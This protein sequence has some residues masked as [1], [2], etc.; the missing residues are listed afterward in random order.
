MRGAT[1]MF[2]RAESYA[3]PTLIRNEPAAEASRWASARPYLTDKRKRTILHRR[4]AALHCLLLLCNAAFS[5]PLRR[6]VTPL[7]A[8]RFSTSAV[9][10]ATLAAA[11]TAGPSND[12]MIACRQLASTYPNLVAFDPQLGVA[13]QTTAL[14]AAYNLTNSVYWNAQN[15]DFRAACAFLPQ[16]AHH[17]SSA[18]KLLNEYKSVPFALKSGG[19]NPAPLY[20]S[21][22][23]GI[24]ISFEPNLNKTVRTDD[25]HHFIVGAGARW[26]SVYKTTSETNQVVVGGRLGHIGVT[27]FVVGGGL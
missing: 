14:E 17:V 23:G 8:M 5:A 27:G 22:D 26:G 4:L 24:L 3:P 6:P 13:N 2:E 11:A 19:H 20:S 16:S 7:C 9:A 12:S 21:T 10:L 1:S 15:A 25:G 18:V